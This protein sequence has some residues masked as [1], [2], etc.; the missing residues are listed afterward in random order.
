M[1]KGDQKEVIKEALKEWL[2]EKYAIFG[3]WT[4]RSLLALLLAAV[5]YLAFKTGWRPYE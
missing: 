2:D 3:R 5:T 1:S 4:L